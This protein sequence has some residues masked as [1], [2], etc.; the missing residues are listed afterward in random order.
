MLILFLRVGEHL[1]NNS[2]NDLPL[3]HSLQFAGKEK[4]MSSSK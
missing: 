1:V 2:E 4:K 3:F